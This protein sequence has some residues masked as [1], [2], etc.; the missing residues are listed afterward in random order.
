MPRA[1]ILRRLRIGRAGD[2]LRR[3]RVVLAK[4]GELALRSQD[5]D[6]ILTEA[7]RLVGEALGTHLAKVVE[8]QPDGLMLRVRAGVGWKPG[9]VGVANIAAA[10]HTSYR[11]ALTSGLPIIS[12]NIAKEIRFSY[13][14]FLIDNGVQAVMNVIILGRTGKAA[15]GVFQVDSRKPRKFSKDDIAFLQ[16]YANLLAAAV[17]RMRG[18]E[19][20]HA[21]EAELRH[22]QRMET[23]GQLAAGVA[24]DFNNVLQSITSA[25]ETV[26]EDAKPETTVHEVAKCA[27][28]SARRGSSITQ[29]LLSY[30]RT[31]VLRPQQID[32][33]M[34]LDEMQRMLSWMLLQGVTIK[35]QTALDLPAVIADPGQLQ[36]ALLNLSINAAHAMPDGG[37]LT[38]EGQLCLET[39]PARVTIA[40][41]DAGIGMDKAT[42]ARA[43]EPFFTTKGVTGSGLGL[44]MV[45]GFADQSGGAMRMESAM[46][47]GTRVELTLPVIASDTR[48]RIPERSNTVSLRESGKLL[49]VDDTADVLL[50][51][52]TFLRRVGFTVSTA[53]GGP[54]ALRILDDGEGFDVL[55]TDYS[56]EGMNGIELIKQIRK[57]RP[58]L[59]AL[60]L[61]GFAEIT[62]PLPTAVEVLTKPFSRQVLITA[63]TDAIR[64]S[65]QLSV[66]QRE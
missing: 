30:A 31:Q 40:V 8:I 65:R 23:I 29:Q 21:R 28:T 32:V 5:L 3:Q 11:A 16:G 15:Y 7:C 22:S 18:L 12:P 43:T 49:L 59:P 27:L 44:S 63:L 62:E 45:S 4:F 25:L 2:T 42:L 36:A 17:E 35:V 38:L 53:R 47:K 33:A 13:P 14:Q 54:E 58:D 46:G 41:T 20:L 19:E 50:A 48:V 34:F 55:L 64:S 1:A 37:T 24:H 57:Q 51:T 10:D 60:I 39:D 61:T 66:I 52:A 9:V 26:L 56:M 6:E